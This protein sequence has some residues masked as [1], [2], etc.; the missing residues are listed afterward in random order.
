MQLGWMGIA[1]QHP[2]RAR[3]LL[4]KLLRGR[5][6]LAKTPAGLTFHADLHLGA[7]AAQLGFAETL[8][9]T[10]AEAEPP[11]RASEC[12]PAIG[13]GWRGGPRAFPPPARP[14]GS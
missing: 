3:A 13:P 6:V 10:V 11:S 1:R 7:L 4:K 8:S 12:S 9:G 14:V 2:A 5:I